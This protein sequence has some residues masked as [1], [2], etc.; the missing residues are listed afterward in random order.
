MTTITQVRQSFWDSFEQF[1]PEYRARKRQNQ[2]RAD[3]RMTFVDYVESLRRNNII[4][5][6]LANRV[7][8]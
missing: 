7:T 1:K 5:E 6:K 3:I 2:Y 8:L 4:S